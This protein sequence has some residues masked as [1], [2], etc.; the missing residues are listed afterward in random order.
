MKLTETVRK[1][2]SEMTKTESK[3]ASCF[4]MDPDAFAFET[5]DTVAERM[6]TSTTSVIRFCR[7]LG[8][9]GYK[10]FS[11]EVRGSLKNELTLPD[12]LSRALRT[13]EENSLAVTVASAV[14]CIEQTLNNSSGEK[15]T[16]AA[17]D[18]ISAKRVFCFG[19]RE[20]FALAH[21]AYTR[22]LSLRPDTFL[23]SV[24]QGGE[25]ESV[26]GLA[27]E[28]VCVF[29]LFHRYTRPAPLILNQLKKQ[30]VR[31]ILITSPPFDEV[32]AD[33]EILLP[34][35][36]NIGGIKNSAVAPVCL[37][38]HLCNTAAKLGGDAT[39]EYMERSEQLFKEFTF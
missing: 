16:R 27:E 2:L 8:F 35:S 4:L 15:M 3:I 36:V 25:I 19:M 23:L 11:E 7:R 20:S 37:I 26:L 39:R 22:F 34:C 31:V 28:D 38:D 30:G 10:A 5:L 1:T 12:K 14:S 32:E 33:A 29:F 6:N 17:E 21:Y 9:S 24:G 13:E 18:I